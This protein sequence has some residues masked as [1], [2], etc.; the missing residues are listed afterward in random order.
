MPPRGEAPTKTPPD[1]RPIA[2]GVAILAV[3]AVLGAPSCQGAPRAVSG[4]GGWEPHAQGLVPGSV[5]ASLLPSASGATLSLELSLKNSV[6]SATATHAD[7]AAFF[8]S[9]PSGGRGGDMAVVA[10]PRAAP[11]HRV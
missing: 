4:G 6:D 3:G 7:E 11:L 10:D 9:G 1:M 8:V 2:I 5:P